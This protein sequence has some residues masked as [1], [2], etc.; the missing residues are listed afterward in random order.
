MG[1][2]SDIPPH[3]LPPSP[4]QLSVTARGLLVFLSLF[5]RLRWLFAYRIVSYWYTLHTHRPRFIE[6][7]QPKAGL[8]IHCCLADLAKLDISIGSNKKSLSPVCCADGEILHDVS[9][10]SYDV[11]G[12]HRRRHPAATVHNTFTV[13]KTRIAGAALIYGPVCGAGPLLL[14][15]TSILRQLLSFSASQ[16]SAARPRWHVIIS[17]AI[18]ARRPWTSA[19]GPG[20][21]PGS[22]S[23]RRRRSSDDDGIRPSTR[24]GRRSQEIKQRL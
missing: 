20:Q 4:C 17:S 5:G 23:T 22:A 1:I 18:V 8:N 14:R 3:S 9:V 19:A 6:V 12:R 15:I 7:W 24:R 10:A 11:C 2:R 21:A 13:K 16:R